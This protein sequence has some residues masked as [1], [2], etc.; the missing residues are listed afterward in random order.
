M[1]YILVS[2]KDRR[3][4]FFDIDHFEEKTGG[5]CDPAATRSQDSLHRI[6]ICMNGTSSY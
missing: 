2:N 5:F 1:G 4:L 6:F 3:G